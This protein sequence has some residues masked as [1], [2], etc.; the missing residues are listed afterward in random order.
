MSLSCFAD[1]ACELSK[2][3]HDLAKLTE[4]RLLDRC[5]EQIVEESTKSNTSVG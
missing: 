4:S 5:V 3:E 1:A 2:L